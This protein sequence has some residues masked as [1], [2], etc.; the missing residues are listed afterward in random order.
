M[1]VS[2]GTILTLKDSDIPLAN[3]AYNKTKTAHEIT[4]VNLA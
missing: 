2:G 3:K 1:K 4:Y